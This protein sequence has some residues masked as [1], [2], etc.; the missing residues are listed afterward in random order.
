MK[1]HTLIVKWEKDSKWTIE[2]GDPVI[3]VVRQ[4]YKD[5]Y[6]G[7]VSDADIFTTDTDDQK[8]IDARVK[9]YNEQGL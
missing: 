9:E 5:T 1:H 4:E 3:S 2:F 8:V 6:K 7:E